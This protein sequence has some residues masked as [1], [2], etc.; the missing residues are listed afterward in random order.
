MMDGGKSGTA[1]GGSPQ[2]DVDAAAET[3]DAVAAALWGENWRG[4]QPPQPQRRHDVAAVTTTTRS[5]DDGKKREEL[6]AV[7]VKVALD[8]DERMRR[9]ETPATTPPL[10]ERNATDKLEA[11][12]LSLSAS[13]MKMSYDDDDVV[14]ATERL[15]V[16]QEELRRRR[17]IESD[18]E[19][20]LT[21]A[22]SAGAG[23]FPT[24]LLDD[25]NKKSS[26]DDNIFKT[27]EQEETSPSTTSEDDDEHQHPPYRTASS[28]RIVSASTPETFP[29]T[30]ATARHHK[31]VPD[32]TT[33]PQWRFGRNAKKSG[34]YSSYSA[35]TIVQGEK[36]KELANDHTLPSNAG[37]V[38]Q[39]IYEDS[40]SDVD[41]EHYL[42]EVAA[43]SGKHD[44]DEDC[45][46]DVK[47]MLGTP[48]TSAADGDALL[49]RV[50][51]AIVP[52]VEGDEDLRSSLLSDGRE[53]PP[54]SIPEIDHDNSDGNKDATSRN[55][56]NHVDEEIR[57]SSR[58]SEGSEISPEPIQDINE[59]SD[60]DDDDDDK[61][62]TSC[63]RRRFCTITL[64]V[65]IVVLCATN[66]LLL[67]VAFGGGNDSGDEKNLRGSKVVGAKEPHKP[68]SSPTS[69]SAPTLS[70]TDNPSTGAMSLTSDM[71]V[72]P[73]DTEKFE[74]RFQLGPMPSAI[75]WSIYDRCSL[76]IFYRCN[77]CYADSPPDYP[78]SFGGCLPS[79]YDK[80]GIE[81]GYV[82]QVSNM[83]GFENYGYEMNYGGEIVSESDDGSYIN[84]QMN[85]FGELDVECDEAL[86]LTEEVSSSY[87]VWRILIASL[88]SNRHCF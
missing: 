15:T 63:N 76:E 72:C 12:V 74:L 57:Q 35:G 75:S 81:R 44:D 85:Y 33:A 46:G 40:S 60:E 58:F 82:M 64:Y 42:G 65:A 79:S 39:A 30:S 2:D 13:I 88:P 18:A 45:M 71:I 50:G 66:A 41:V 84:L 8:L 55:R 5:L 36:A 27:P 62:D 83:T 73:E 86:G 37:T 68:T 70:P 59:D 26:S 51:K 22:G 9:M 11:K 23:E 24:E 78:I 87:L 28:P 56:T 49:D 31:S 80:T 1:R 32:E 77:K 17:E 14:D 10:D 19:S 69:S 53:T 34:G 3:T 7:R 29:P 67:I 47:A 43:I 16:M 20:G 48:S 4:S 54:G 21:A 6:R 61:D 38:Q 25:V 52:A